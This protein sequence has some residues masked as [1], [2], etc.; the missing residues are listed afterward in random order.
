M[1]GAGFSIERHEGVEVALCE[2][3]LGIP[4][5]SHG[6]STRRADGADGFDLGSARPGDESAA[7]RRAR[8]ARALGLDP[9]HGPAVLHQVHGNRVVGAGELAAGRPPS[10]DA[11]LLVRDRPGPA[12]VG[13][14]TADCVPLLIADVR[15][16]AVAAVHAGW[17]GTVAG[18]AAAAVRDLAEEWIGPEDLQVAIG[19]AI[20]PCCYP[21]GADVAAAV[22]EA[23]G[24]GAAAGRGEAGQVVVDLRLANR[25]QLEREGV[26]A[27]RIHTAPWCTVCAADR[28]FSFRRDAEA[29]G[30][31]MAC[32]GWTTSP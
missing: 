2:P 26:P 6:F 13:V 21:V 17:R 28:F 23:C 1:S 27:G 15:G 22:V 11:G 18:I 5:V 16:R 20:G 31:Q 19:P 24:D 14:R 4:G 9:E 3:L 25:R 7:Q 10:A 30:R 12:S 32:I 29:A 8:L